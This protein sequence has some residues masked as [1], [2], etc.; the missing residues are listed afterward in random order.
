MKEIEAN[1]IMY[2]TS[3]DVFQLSLKENSK[4]PAVLETDWLFTCILNI[5]W[6]ANFIILSTTNTGV[7]EILLFV[8]MFLSSP[9]PLLWYEYRLSI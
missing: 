7:W 4:F 5:G 9:T 6:S 8:R 3:L 1:F 2:F